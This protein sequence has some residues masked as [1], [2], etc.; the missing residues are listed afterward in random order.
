VPTYDYRCSACGH[1]CEIFQK[2]SDTPVDVCPQ[3][4]SGPFKRIITSVG[5]IFKGSGFHINDYKGSIAAA[6]A[7]SG[8]STATP[9][10]S[11][12]APAE[13]KAEASV[14]TSDGGSG[15][16]GSSGKAVA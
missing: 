10:A 13:S 14:S 16:Q 1:T 15:D 8:E 12:S 7:S 2:M 4:Q 6:P 9:S 11:S 5:V 3:C